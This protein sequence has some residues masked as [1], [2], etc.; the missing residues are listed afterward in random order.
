V[1]V[2]EN[3]SERERERAFISEGEGGREEGRDRE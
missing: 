3:P 2:G 1:G